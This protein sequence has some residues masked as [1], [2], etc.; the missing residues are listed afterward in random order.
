MK[1]FMSEINYKEEVKKCK[2]M[3]DVMGKNGLVSGL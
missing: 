2:I 3:E 1:D